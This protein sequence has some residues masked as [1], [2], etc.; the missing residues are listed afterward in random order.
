MA[1]HHAKH[2]ENNRRS[3]WAYVCVRENSNSGITLYSWCP[4]ICAELNFQVKMLSVHTNRTKW[5]VFKFLQFEERRKLRLK[6]N[7][8][9]HENEMQRVLFEEG[10]RKASFLWR[11][12]VDCRLQY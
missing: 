4:R 12:S 8:R 5:R 2:R 6:N 10:F 9:T 3:L 11:I 7:I 1:V